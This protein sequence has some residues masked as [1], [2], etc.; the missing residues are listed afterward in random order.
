MM[1]SNNSSLPE[2]VFE[3]GDAFGPPNCTVPAYWINDSHVPCEDTWE[4]FLVR[5]SVATEGFGLSAVATVGVMANGLSIAVLTR[6]TMKTQVS[7]ST[8]T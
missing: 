4:S 8:T 6:R 3:E 1:A 7:C 5:F 2:E